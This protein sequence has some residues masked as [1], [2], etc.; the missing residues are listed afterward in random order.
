[1]IK[2]IISILLLYFILRD[3]N[4]NDILSAIKEADFLILL[5]AFS[6]HFIGLLLSSIRW[7]ILLKAQHIDS[8]LK[9]LFKSYLVASF[10]NHFLP[11]TVGGDSIRTYDS[12]K[13]GE[14]KEK[15]FAVVILDRFLGLLTLLLFAVISMILSPHLSDKIP[16]II[17]WIFLIT[18]GALLI[19]WFILSPPLKYFENLK[20]KNKGIISKIAG[21]IFKI[22]TA[23]SQF[24]D[25]KGKLFSAL[26]LSFLLQLNVVF[27][28]YLI[29]QSL[30][31]EVAFIDY[32]LIVPLTIFITMIPI[33]F[34]GV[35]LRESA[36]FLFLSQ[37][38]VLQAEA[39]AFAWLEYGMLLLLGIIGGIFYTLRK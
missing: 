20:N 29:S 22:D 14:N 39:I 32:F 25:K 4:F 21:F 15:A 19:V 18:I 23:F 37:F 2:A 11:S 1:M 24:S 34:N 26:G 16:G 3:V 27:Y 30:G 28:Y 12:W 35:G 7:Q 9:F 33:S 13:L 6:L 8:K 10:F 36:L 38:G 17:F 31:L 5:L